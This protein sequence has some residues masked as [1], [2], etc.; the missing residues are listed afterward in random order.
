MVD[1][2]IGTHRLLSRDIIYKD[3]GIAIKEEGR[4][5]RKRRSLIEFCGAN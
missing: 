2:V 5:R 4:T 1:I 3:L